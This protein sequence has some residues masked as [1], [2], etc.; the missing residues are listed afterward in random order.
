MLPSR[1]HFLADSCRQHASLSRL[2]SEPLG[3]PVPGPIVLALHWVHLLCSLLSCRQPLSWM[4][5]QPNIPLEVPLNHWGAGS[6]INA[7]APQPPGD[8]S[9]VPSAGLLRGPRANEPS[10]PRQCGLRNAR[11]APSFLFPA[12][13]WPQN[14]LRPEPCLRGPPAETGP[15]CPLSSRAQTACRQTQRICVRI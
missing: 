10:H 15:L 13:T 8:S 14:H 9:E 11:P 3:W 4:Q 12:I 6:V 2:T 7:S 5:S 1:R